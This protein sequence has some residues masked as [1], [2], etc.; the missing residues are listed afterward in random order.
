MTS[1]VSGA[2]TVFEGLFFVG[3]FAPKRFLVARSTHFFG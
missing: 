1:V 2:M 3:S